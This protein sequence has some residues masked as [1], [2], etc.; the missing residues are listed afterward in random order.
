MWIQIFPMCLAGFILALFGYLFWLRP[1][2][3]LRNWIA[4]W[5]GILVWSGMLALEGIH[6]SAVLLR[7]SACVFLLALMFLPSGIEH[8]PLSSAFARRPWIL[9]AI[10]GAAMLSALILPLSWM[11]L[12]AI[13]LLAGLG[14]L[15]LLRMRPSYAH[16]VMGFIFML[17]ALLRALLP[18][19]MEFDLL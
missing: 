13:V 16:L 14:C 1:E 3:F 5:G 11:V 12:P 6:P 7:A 4:F 15:T 17:W 10:A 9:P 8:L 2:R 18:V 19:Q